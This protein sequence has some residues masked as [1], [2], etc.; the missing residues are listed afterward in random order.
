MWFGGS[1]D[2]TK[3]QIYDL[4]FTS[5]T[6]IRA[7]QNSPSKQTAAPAGGAV[8]L[9]RSFARIKKTKYNLIYLYSRIPLTRTTKGN[10]EKFE[11]AGVR[12]KGVGGSSSEF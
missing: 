12:D 9:E 3:S 11:L 4:F 7:N 1:F 5:D 6:H 8:C 2:H 10:E